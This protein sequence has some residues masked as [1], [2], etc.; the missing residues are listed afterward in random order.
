MFRST[1]I[2]LVLA[3]QVFAQTEIPIGTWRTHYSYNQV[4]EVIVV[5]NLVYASSQNGL[6]IYDQDDNSITTLTK[7]SGLQG[8]TISSMAYDPASNQLLLGYNSGNLDMIE[9]N[10]IKN[11][12]FVTTSQIQGSKSIND[13]TMFAGN[14]YLS[15][16]FGVLKFNLQKEEVSETY[17]ELGLSTDSIPQKLV[18]NAATV[19]NDSLFIASEQGVLAA[20][21]VENINLL[22]YKNWRRFGLSDGIPNDE[23]Q[24]IAAKENTIIAGLK[25][26]GLFVYNGSWADTNTLQNTSFSDLMATEGLV[27][28]DSVVYSFDESYNI[29]NLGVNQKVLSVDL[30]DNNAI[31]VGS[32]SDGLLKLVEGSVTEALLPSG[33]STNDVFKIKYENGVI[34]T[35]QGGYTNGANPLGKRGVFA[36][37]ENGNWQTTEL[38]NE[39]QDLV[40]VLEYNNKVF[41]ATMGTG[42][43]SISNDGTQLIYDETNS[44]LISTFSEDGLRVPAIATSQSGLWALNYG[45]NRVH[46]LNNDLEWQSVV[47]SSGLSAFAVDMLVV[48]DQLWLIVDPSSGGGIVVVDPSTG[49]SRY[50]SSASGDGGLASTIVNTLAMDKDGLIW[51]GTNLG[52]SVFTNPSGVLSGQVNAIEPIFENRQL[53][54]DEV[55][56]DIEVDGGNRKWIGTRRGLWLFDDQADTQI[57][58]FNKSNSPLPSDN[59]IDLEINDKTGEVF[60]GTEKGIVSYRGSSTEGTATHNT[61][62]IFP[63]PVRQDFNGTVGISGLVNDAL[64]K[65]TDASGKLIW[66]TQANGGTAT[67]NVK[68]YNGNRANTGIY[69]V[70]SASADGE[71]TFVGK[72]AI[73]N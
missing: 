6:F 20:N 28:A 50:L 30:D 60:I 10:E 39:I 2:L 48:R 61:V 69:Y 5:N 22:D 17:R 19:F 12:D 35:L 57:R 21:L 34:Y 36:V 67:W 8:G 65:I 33:P 41:I 63:N 32:G 70:F 56:T 24:V 64:I 62:E 23:T 46:L 18:V 49:N 47:T 68:D 37:F 4:N 71:E 45:T 3:T 38:Q 27:I 59:I 44:P 15:T 16:D 13:I 58:F 53:L 55:V 7:S 73:I 52:V 26:Q 11:F 43:I 14:A 51:A 29:Q 40:D 9:G 25:D 42:I 72:I 31:W 54:R 1:F 66:R